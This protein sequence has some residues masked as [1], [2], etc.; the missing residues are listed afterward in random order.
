LRSIKNASTHEKEGKPT[1]SISGHV[2]IANE[3]AQIA[4]D[5]SRSLSAPH[6]GDSRGSDIRIE[7]ATQGHRLDDLMA[8]SD[9]EMAVIA[10]FLHEREGTSGLPY[11]QT[12]SQWA[13][14]CSKRVGSNQIVPERGGPGRLEI[15]ADDMIRT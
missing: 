14:K 15:Q 6:Q 3:S 2:S 8:H 4:V 5:G 9:V 11:L 1:V 13:T 7:R 10:P 12:G